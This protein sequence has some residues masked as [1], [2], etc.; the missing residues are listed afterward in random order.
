MKNEKM[1]KFGKMLG[2]AALGIAVVA[3]VIKKG[4][5]DDTKILDE[6]TQD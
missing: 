5:L 6:C 3:L 4:L 1:Y 2:C